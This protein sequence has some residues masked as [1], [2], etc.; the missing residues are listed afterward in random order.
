MPVEA[1]RTDI[2]SGF[3]WISMRCPNGSA[4]IT[5]RGLATGGEREHQSVTQPPRPL[6]EAARLLCGGPAGAARS[7]AVW[8]EVGQLY[9]YHGDVPAE[10]RLLKLTEEAGD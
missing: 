7:K 3:D 4:T 10:V 5:G 8:D 6:R 2:G 9:A 1:D